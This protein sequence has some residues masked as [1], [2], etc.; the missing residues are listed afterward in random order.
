M[1]EIRPRLT[2]LPNAIRA[3]RLALALTRDQLAER[4]GLKVSTIHKL[5]G[6]FMDSI[7]PKTVQAL[8]AAL[9]CDPAEISAVVEVSA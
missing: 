9:S 5:E 3:R 6:D 7:S 1:S 4:S 2:A 8:A